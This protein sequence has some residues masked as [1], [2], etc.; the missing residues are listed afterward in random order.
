[1]RSMRTYVDEACVVCVH[2]VHVVDEKYAAILMYDG[3]Y[4]A[5]LT[6][7]VKGFSSDC[8]KYV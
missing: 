8:N 6:S 1:M 3:Q 4:A 5:I 7:V 2:T